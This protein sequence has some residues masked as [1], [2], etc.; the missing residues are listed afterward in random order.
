MVKLVDTADSKSAGLALAS[1]SLATSN[2]TN[3]YNQSTTSIGKPLWE[4]S[5]DSMLHALKYFV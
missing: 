2:Q 5:P 3:S 1:S 4:E